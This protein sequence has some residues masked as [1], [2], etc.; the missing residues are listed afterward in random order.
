MLSENKPKQKDKSKIRNAKKKQ[1]ELASSK[2]LETRKVRKVSE[3]YLNDDIQVE[4]SLK[5]RHAAGNIDDDYAKQKQKE[6]DFFCDPF[7]SVKLEIEQSSREDLK[8]QRDDGEI[9]HDDEV[10]Q[11]SEPHSG[12]SNESPNTHLAS[13]YI[14]NDHEPVV[15]KF[16]LTR[17]TYDELELLFHPR[18]DRIFKPIN[19]EEKA[20]RIQ[21][22]EGVF[23]PERPVISS[24]SNMRLLLDRLQES[25]STEFIDGAGELRNFQKLVGDDVYRLVSDKKFTP[26]YVPPMPMK[27]ESINKII[28]EKKF[29]KIYISHM[30]FDQHHLFTNEHHVA[31][32][33]ERLFNEFD[34]RKK[35]DV[36]G[37]L[38]H[39]LKNLREVKSSKF[40]TSPEGPKSARTIRNEELSLN[41]QVQK[42]RQ[43][44]HVEQRYDHMVVKSL[45]ENWRDLKSIRSKQSYAFT[46]ISLKIQKFQV[47]LSEKQVEWQQQYD[48]ELN[49]MIAEE[50]DEY[51]AM[52]QKHKDFIKSVNDPESITDAQDVVKKPKKPDIDKIVAQLNE[53]FDG[54]P[55]EEPELNII[56]SNENVPEKQPAPKEKLK[57]IGKFSYRFELE[58]DGEIVGSTKH[59]K[60]DEDFTILIQSAFILKLTK[61][62]PENI[63]LLVS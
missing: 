56:M 27:F 46:G 63:K 39:K 11:K 59:C 35:L 4:N 47:N 50:F 62:L 16:E 38:S 31:K 20:L 6:V 24:T 7:S 10:S 13:T 53:T 43:K 23:I 49:E 51:H 52:K 40:P 37:T 8:G 58:V 15:G 41:H 17:I 61:Q 12:R 19:D 21:K 36:V 48:L 29:L 44:L 2:K 9:E 1:K 45:L 55:I 30:A 25:G 57:K 33:V 28:N 42:V 26:I 60:L 5:L 54:I 14:G 22:D 3:K 18:A 32:V 34:R